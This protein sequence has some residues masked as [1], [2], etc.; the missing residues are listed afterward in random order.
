MAT[1]REYIG[2]N[3]FSVQ[4][5][6]TG[7]RGIKLFRYR[8]F[9]WF[10]YLSDRN[11]KLKVSL[12]NKSI[13]SI[14]YEWKL[15]VRD[16][17][18]RHYVWGRQSPIRG[19]L[20]PGQKNEVIDFGPLFDEGHYSFEMRWKHEINDGADFQGLAQFYVENNDLYITKWMQT[21]GSG[22]IGAILGGIIAALITWAIKN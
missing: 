19:S 8:P 6:L 12:K 15:S 17:Q 1:T 10:A 18:S 3:G 7:F 5:N 22:L 13:E 4:V 9:G 11:V 16:I 2:R 14:P 20:K 21:L